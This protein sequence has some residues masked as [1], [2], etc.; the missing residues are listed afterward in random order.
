VTKGKLEIQTENVSRQGATYTTTNNVTNNVT[1]KLA[2]TTSETGERLAGMYTEDTFYGGSLA[3]GKLVR[4]LR[5]E[6]GLPYISVKD[7]NRAKMNIKLNGEIVRDD[8]AETFTK[9]VKKPVRTAVHETW[10][11][12]AERADEAHKE[13][14]RERMIEGM[15]FETDPKYLQGIC[16]NGRPVE[17]K[18]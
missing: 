14:L 3:I 10:T 1:L 8:K 15:Q 4:D 16:M 18:I 12:L 13:L 6:D 11:S 9:S 5:S 2:E 17:N 7:E